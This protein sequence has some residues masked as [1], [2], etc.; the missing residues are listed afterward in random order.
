MGSPSQCHT[1]L[2]DET[3]I[4]IALTIKKKKKNGEKKYDERR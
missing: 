2:F 3:P 4:V 1:V